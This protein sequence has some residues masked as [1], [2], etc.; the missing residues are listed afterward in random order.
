MSD[1]HL[2]LQHNPHEQSIAFVQAQGKVSNFSPKADDGDYSHLRDDSIM[3]VKDAE[4]VTKN[5]NNYGNNDGDDNDFSSNY[6]NQN[7]LNEINEESQNDDFLNQQ[8]DVNAIDNF[9][10]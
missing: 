7:G 10:L 4:L 1:N 3:K 6:Q 5:K 8:Q 9:F 2:N